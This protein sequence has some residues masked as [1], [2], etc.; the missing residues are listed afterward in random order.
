[1]VLLS[2][3]QVNSSLTALGDFMVIRFT[4][5]PKR[6]ELVFL[7]PSFFLGVY[8]ANDLSVQIQG[9]KGDNFLIKQNSMS[10]Q[11]FVFW[12]ISA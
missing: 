6:R 7:S 9:H 4:S 1:M 3:I 11:E 5:P 10:V 2:V 8:C 12:C